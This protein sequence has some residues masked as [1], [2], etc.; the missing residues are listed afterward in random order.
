[1]DDKNRLNQDGQYW[2]DAANLAEQVTCVRM[3]R[4]MV[5]VADELAK[6]FL[7]SDP[8]TTH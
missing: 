6:G 2:E 5:P 1:M 4:R 3:V 8:I 7:S